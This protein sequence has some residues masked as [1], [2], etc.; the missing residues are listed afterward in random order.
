MAK[1]R[2]RDRDFD[3]PTADANDP[4]ETANK[5]SDKLGASDKPPVSAPTPVE[6]TRPK[7]TAPETA[8]TVP[9]RPVS[10][11]AAAISLEVFG[12]ISGVKP[13]Q[14]AGFAWYAKRQRLGP[15]SVWSWRHEYA[16]FLARAI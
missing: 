11:P 5:S 12:R 6:K 2:M 4:P 1:T 8:P 10:T 7:T 9:T 13:D 14:L 3:A 16:R 15:Q